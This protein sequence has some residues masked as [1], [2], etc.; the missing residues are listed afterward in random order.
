[1]TQNHYDTCKLT[2]FLHKGIRRVLMKIYWQ[3]RRLVAQ[4]E[5]NQLARRFKKKN[6]EMVG[7]CAKKWKDQTYKTS[8]LMGS[9][10]NKKGV[11]GK[12]TWMR[13]TQREKKRLSIT[14]SNATTVVR[15]DKD[16]D[17]LWIAQFSRRIEGT[18]KDNKLKHFL[19]KNYY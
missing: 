7:T 13:T 19:L 9:W 10:R 16:G 18:L 15:L 12:K 5:W 4:L 8:R 2:F 17:D 6:M 11:G 3:I 1:M 14:W